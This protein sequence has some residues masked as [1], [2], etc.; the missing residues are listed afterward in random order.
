MRFNV[1]SDVL[2]GGVGGEEM[3]R[4]VRPGMMVVMEV[5]CGTRLDGG[6]AQASDGGMTKATA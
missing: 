4:C 1:R 5:N 2:Y 6:R 3:S